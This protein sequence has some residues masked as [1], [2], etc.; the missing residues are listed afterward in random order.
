[1]AGRRKIIIFVLTVACITF[2]IIIYNIARFIPRQGMPDKKSENPP[3][4]QNT[5]EQK[6]PP[7]IAEQ[8]VQPEPPPQTAPVPVPKPQPIPKPKQESKPKPKPAPGKTSKIAPPKNSIGVYKTPLLDK[9]SGRAKNINLASKKINGYVVEP[10]GTFSF[11]RVVGAR[12]A[13]KGYK[14]A[15]VI[16]QGKYVED[17]GGGICQLSST[18][19]N[20]AEKAGLQILER[21]PHSK[22]VGYVAE[23]HDAAIDYGNMDLKFKNS[24]EYPIEIRAGLENGEV[25]AF[26]IKLQRKS[27]ASP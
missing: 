25:Y 4:G 11:N 16:M 24:K 8:P 10:G 23:G 27:P 1:M 7:P 17:T 26:I 20:A 5:E 13:E 2:S 19:F 14:S 21:H 18:L 6:A 15:K 22:K 3:I 9:N 12:T